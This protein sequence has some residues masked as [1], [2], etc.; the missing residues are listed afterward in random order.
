MRLHKIVV[1]IDFSDA[2]LA[3]ARWA[4]SRVAPDGQLFLVHVL[5]E[6]FAPLYLRSYADPAL[7][8]ASSYSPGLYGALKG[9]GDALRSDRVRVGVRSGN[10]AETLARVA[11]EVKADMLCVGR[12]GRRQGGS[13]FGATTPQRLLAHARVP[14]LIVPGTT[15]DTTARV[16]GGQRVIAAVDARAGGEAILEVGAA[17]ASAWGTELEA[18]HVVEAET[19]VQSLGRYIGRLAARNGQGVRTDE[20]RRVGIEALGELGL[21]SLAD[22]WLNSR[23]AAVHGSAGGR[24]SIRWGDPGPELVSYV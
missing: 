12:G 13:R 15:D 19:R 1:G 16:V 9:F 6:P 11:E 8:R 18:V 10:P 3:A 4:A 22:Q 5:P 2:S 7:N 23:L 14:V 24:V 20:V 17:L 21:T